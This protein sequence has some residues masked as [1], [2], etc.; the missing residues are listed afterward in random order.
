ME[1]LEH[2]SRDILLKWAIDYEEARIS[3]TGAL[4][5]QTG[6]H[7]GRSAGAK[8]IVFDEITKDKVNWNDNK[9]IMPNDFH[10]IKS[11]MLTRLDVGEGTVFKQELFANNDTKN[12][13][14]LNVYTTLAWHSIFSK[15]MFVEKSALGFHDS[16]ADEWDLYYFHDHLSSPSVLISFTEKAILISGTMYAGEM[17]KSVFTV[18]NFCLPNKGVLPM[19]CSV[20]VS[21]AGDSSAIFFGLSGTGKTTLSSDVRRD[22]VGDDEHS[23]S[24][25]GLYNF[26][27]G[28]Y[29][30]VINLSKSDEPQIW[31]A[32]N[33]DFSI[34]ENVV[35]GNDDTPNFDDDSIT[36]N[37]RG[38]YPIS[39]ISNFVESC[40]AGHPTNVIMLTCD[41]FGVLPP[42][43]KLSYD[44]AI[45]HF[46]L[47]YTAKVAGTEVG[48]VEPEV[49]FSYCYGAPFMPLS[50][51]VYGDLLRDKL[52]EHNPNC[53]LVN[54]GWTGGPYG[55]GSRMPISLTRSII[56]AIH[57]GT[58]A[59]CSTTL[60][61]YTGLRIPVGHDLIEQNLLFPEKTWNDKEMYIAEAAGLM[62]LF[63]HKR[64]FLR[65]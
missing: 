58:L 11:S 51:G 5:V 56:D 63:D 65:I 40:S 49:T 20:N 3:S 23:W 34:L 4:V 33:S 52:V 25:T 6:I 13:L 28:C 45:S 41:A 26:E 46:L 8:R 15:N 57:D 59:N 60:H 24:D 2:Q 43:S 36:Q 1:I 9:K 54:T 17:K 10:E 48:I 39:S 42:V 61:D 50:P 16:D 7:T 55:V 35:F 18:L 12:Q 62:T 21:K 31:D 30:K 53:W 38:S 27:G 32:V 29:A 19:H 37:T 47:G 44:D 22:L 14:K 64:H